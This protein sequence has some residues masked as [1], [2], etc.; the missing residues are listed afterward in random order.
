M[1]TLQDQQTGSEKMTLPQI[2][3]T[4]GLFA[5]TFE[6]LSAIAREKQ[7]AINAIEE[8]YETSLRM[9]CHRARVRLLAL[10]KAI[11]DNQE[12]FTA[13]RTYVFRGIKFGM[14]KLSDELTIPD[15]E[16]TLALIHKHMEIPEGYINVKE[17]IDREAVKTLS[18][19][20]LTKLG[21]ALVTGIDSVTVKPASSEMDK[22]IMSLLDTE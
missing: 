7:D 2:E 20:T 21:C 22:A 8:K 3:K 10:N 6:Q 17:S 1:L 14:R 9:A 5:D 12:L 4:A 15:E 18:P 13:P 11:A 19:E 16:L